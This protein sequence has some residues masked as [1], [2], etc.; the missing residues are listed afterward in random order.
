MTAPSTYRL[1]VFVLPEAETERLFGKSQFRWFAQEMTC[2]GD[3]CAEVT[4]GLYVS[5]REIQNPAAIVA[6]LAPALGLE[7]TKDDSSERGVPA[8]KE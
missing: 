4:T 6:M 3:T 1:M 7:E 8:P 2:G 5:E